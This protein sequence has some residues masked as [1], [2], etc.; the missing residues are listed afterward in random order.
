MIAPFLGALIFGA[1]RTFA[2]EYSPNTWQMV[3]GIAMLLVITFL[4]DGLWSLFR[5]RPARARPAND[6]AG[7]A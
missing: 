6:R 7:A 1:I 5:T 3:L 4:P 2:Y